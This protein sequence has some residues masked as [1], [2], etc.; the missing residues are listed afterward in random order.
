MDLNAY[1]SPRVLDGPE[2]RAGL[3]G[4]SE[5]VDGLPYWPFLDIVIIV[6]ILGVIVALLMAAEMR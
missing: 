4:R 3:G 1:E 2:V 5:E 6:I